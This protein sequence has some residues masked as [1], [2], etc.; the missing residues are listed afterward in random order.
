M[1]IKDIIIKIRTDNNLTQ[2]ELANILHISRSSIALYEKGLRTPNIDTLK[3]LSSK[4]NIDIREFYNKENIKNIPRKHRSLSLS[5]IAIFLLASVLEA[6]NVVDISNKYGYNIYDDKLLVQKCNDICIVRINELWFK[7]DSEQ[8]YIVKDIVHILKKDNYYEYRLLNLNNSLIK[9]NTY[10]YYLIFVNESKRNI[11]SQYYHYEE[12][13]IDYSPFI[14]ELK[15]YD[16][17]LEYYEQTGE[18]K[19]KIDYYLNLINDK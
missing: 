14:E 9:I 5:S 7:G 13:N 2:E 16:E 3:I 1:K 11:S 6:C 12:I 17:S 18:C 19:A 8:E 15:G 4:F 10:H